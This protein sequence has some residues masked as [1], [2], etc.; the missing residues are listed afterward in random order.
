MNPGIVG[1]EPLRIAIVGPTASG[2]SALAVDVARRLGAVVVNGDPFQAYRGIPIGTGQ[3]SP[4]EQ[5]GV[6]HVGYGVLDLD[7]V[8]DP[9]SFGARVR[10]SSSGRAGR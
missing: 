7:T 6:P 9:A 10:G 3:P 5:G 4:E 8:L 1:G 2:K